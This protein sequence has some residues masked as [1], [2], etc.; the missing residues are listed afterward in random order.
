MQTYEIVFQ[1]SNLKTH[2]HKGGTILEAACNTGL[3]IVSVCGG[4][5]IC[6]R[7]KVQI[8]DGQVTPATSDEKEAFSQRELT[9]GYRLACQTRPLSNCAVNIPPE[10]LALEQRALADGLETPTNVDPP[11]RE[12]RVTLPAE[13]YSTKATKEKCLTK[14]L[15]QQ[16][17]IICKTVDNQVLRSL[18]SKEISDDFAMQASV[19]SDEIIALRSWP[20]K[21]L[22]LAIDLGTT[23]IAGY[24]LDIDDG[25]T[26]ASH[27][28]PNPQSSYGDDIIARL[29]HARD[30]VSGATKIQRLVVNS[31]NEL[32]AR[33]CAE[34]ALNSE[35]II[36]TVI[37][38]NTAMHHLLLKLPVEQLLRP[39][40]LPYVKDALDVKSRDLGLQLAP[41][42]Y[43][44]LLPNIAGFVGADHIA[45]LLASGAS[46]AD[47]TT[48]A[49]DIGTNTEVS[50]ANNDGISCVSCASGPAFEGGHISHG[51]K[52]AKGA[53]DRLQI[54]DNAVQ[55]HTIGGAPAIGLCGSA[56]LDAVSELLRSGVLDASGRMHD[57]PLVRTR[58]DRREF[59]LV[60]AKDSARHKSITLTQHDV[61]E[62]QLAKAAIRTGIEILLR[63]NSVTPADIEQVIVAGA[64]GSYLELTSA[65]AIGMLP[66]L[67]LDRF[68]QIGN[69]S[70]TGAR[71]ALISKDRRLEAAELA[72]RIEYIELS[73][74]PGFD[75]IYTRSTLIEP[76]V[77]RD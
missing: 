15:S 16:K 8:T 59:L 22:G 26:L 74:A 44:H 60:P 6:R 21:S 54:T 73:A 49:I 27:G 32:A 4:H 50:L 68:R 11:V 76:I 14:S 71:M 19:R 7:C 47:K 29:V 51:M 36:E 62:L 42:S 40:F 31:I 13:F 37:V 9:D 38:G 64:F 35:D 56:V 70:G 28:I 5:G 45:M 65:I 77:W 75:K 46:H 63:S 48:L 1:P 34:A 67:P 66:S 69:A 12:Y 61:R 72:R 17:G 3:D 58:N 41:G 57:H 2:I 55:Y 39:P 43:V 53:I 25:H 20:A 24:L 18:N 52:A 23:K 33:L 30:S 10:S